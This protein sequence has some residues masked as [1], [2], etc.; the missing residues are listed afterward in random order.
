MHAL[1]K[2]EK[3]SDYLKLVLSA[4]YNERIE[5]YLKKQTLFFEEFNIINELCTALIKISDYD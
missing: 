2:Y 3:Y 4:F 5:Y 1:D